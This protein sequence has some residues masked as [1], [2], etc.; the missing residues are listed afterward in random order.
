MKKWLILFLVLAVAGGLFAQE[1]KWSGGVSTGLGL[2][3]DETAGIDLFNDDSFEGTLGFLR[4]EYTNGNVGAAIRI[5]AG[6]KDDNTPD[7]GL[8]HAKVWVNFLDDK[9]YIATGRLDDFKWGKTNN[10]W[11]S[12]SGGTGAILEVK[13]IDGLSLGTVLKTNLRDD[14]AVSNAEEFFKNI[15][16]GASYDKAD[17][18]YI[19][20]AMQLGEQRGNDAQEA[21]YCFHLNV[22]PNLIFETSGMFKN[23]GGDG[24]LDSDHFQNIGY[25][26][27]P[28]VFKAGV[29]LTEDPSNIKDGPLAMSFMPWV[30]YAI[31]N[32]PFTVYGEV[33][34]SAASIEDPKFKWEIKAPRITYTINDAAKIQLY[35]LLTIPE[36]AAASTDPVHK[37]KFNFT[38]Y[39]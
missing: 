32:T 12:Y 39:F 20:A 34:A 37:V 18:L 5:Q 15:A 13:P 28:D 8:H 7:Y 22:V 21:L 17:L 26:I 4:A 9:I 24:I 29:T 33:K 6:F 11:A 30:E 10:D 31:S 1:L 38:W 25:K 2:S 36:E 23:I 16:F 35:Y 27:I 19:A 14:L 3:S